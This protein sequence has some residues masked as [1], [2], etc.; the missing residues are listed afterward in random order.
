MKIME[1]MIIKIKVKLGTRLG[2]GTNRTKLLSSKTKWKIFTTS[3]RNDTKRTY[4]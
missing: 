3:I 2:T 4:V 1:I